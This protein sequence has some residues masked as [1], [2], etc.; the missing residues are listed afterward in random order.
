MANRPVRDRS[1]D[2]TR[3]VLLGALRGGPAHGYDVMAKL[4]RW[5]MEWW[6]DVQSGSIY[7]GLAKLEKEGLIAVT[8][9]G[10]NGNRP[11]RRTYE[12]TEAG[13]EEFRQLL[14]RA[15]VGITRFS[16]PI[17]V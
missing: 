11:V 10:R 16:R 5:S 7:A 9:T 6:A 8:S 3:I 13:R 12:I 1:G 17:D 15:W 2:V 4:R 14:R